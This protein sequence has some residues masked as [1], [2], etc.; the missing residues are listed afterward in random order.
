[1]IV[2]VPKEIKPDERRVAMTPAGAAAVRHHGHTVIVERSA[3]VGSGFSDEDYRAA[4]AR[5]SSDAATVW[6]RSTM[7]L[8][9]KEPLP[10]EYR[11][12]RPGLII[13]T[14][15]HLAADRRL[16]RELIRQRVT[17]I[18][19]KPCNSKTAVCRCW[20]R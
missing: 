17:A 5:V 16:S 11:L 15:L 8:K 12:M 9:V 13:F 18:V 20:R 14:Y 19:T 7:V 4:G 3:G 6:R 2:G 10:V 1:M